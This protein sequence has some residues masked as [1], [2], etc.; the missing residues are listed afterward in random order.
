VEINGWALAG[1]VAVAVGV[2]VFGPDLIDDTGPP[3]Q[4]VLG[5]K[6]NEPPPE[7]LY[8]DTARVL[9]YLGQ[10]DG[11]LTTAERRSFQQTD[12]VGGSVGAGGVTLS[13]KQQRV[14]SVEQDVTAGAT[15]RFYRLL[16]ALKDGR[17]SGHRWLFTIDAHLHG[18]HTADRVDDTLQ[19]VRVG[20]FLRITRARAY[21]APY[22]AV[23]PKTSY[24]LSY[25]AGDLERPR[26]PLFA[27]VS[28]RGRLAAD[29][30]RRAVGDNPRIPIVVPTLN[31]S[32]TTRAP[33]KFIVPVR[34]D[35]LT[36]EPSSLAGEMTIVGKVIYLDSR[37]QAHVA[38]SDPNPPYWTDLETVHTFAP[39]LEHAQ[40]PLLRLLD[41][42]RYAHKRRKLARVVR[43]SVTFAA[44]IA[45]V[46]PIAMYQ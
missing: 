17:S 41:L 42:G 7:Y 46:L 6:A 27:Q 24:S 44:P 18:R 2:G 31:S 16:A 4:D 22:A 39:A 45:V 29:R 11:G 37:V 19:H 43:N 35:G 5:F 36:S 9:A 3:S 21:V 23:Y 32:R 1:I 34:R 40:V 30:Y 33:V 12:E 13:G 20:D 14:G 28:K 15:D 8:L 26:H 10:I 25:L 38:S